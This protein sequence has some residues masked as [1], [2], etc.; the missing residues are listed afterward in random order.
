MKHR[1]RIAA[2]G[3]FTLAV[4]QAHAVSL[5]SSGVTEN[6]NGMGPTGTTPPVDWT[7]WSFAG[8]NSTWGGAIPA[9][10]MSGG[11]QLTPTASLGVFN[12]NPAMPSLGSNNNNGLN[13]G[14]TTDLTDRA[15]GTAPTT[16]AGT[17]IQVLVTNDTGLALSAITVSYDIKI[18]TA[19]Q[20]NELPGYRL[21][22]AT[23]PAAGAWTAA[24]ALDAVVTSANAVGSSFTV[25]ATITFAGGPVAA[26]ANFLLRWVDDNAQQTSPDQIYAID[27]VSIIPSP[28]VW[29]F[30]LPV[31]LMWLRRRRPC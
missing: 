9:S 19:W 25:T 13:V 10:A 26:G 2:I 18:V 31:S 1:S 29:G 27:N 30:A 22:Y 24:P 28:A 17:A 16:I 6:F 7:I 11:T 15:L 14:F 20:N 8:S 3:L 12:Q 21:F 5:G 23:G 4:S